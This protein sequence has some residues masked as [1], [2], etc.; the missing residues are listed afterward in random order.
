ML[1]DQMADL[2]MAA[3]EAPIERR[4]FAVVGGVNPRRCRIYESAVRAF[5][6]LM[7]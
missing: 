6:D 1:M 7:I 5:D 3:A 4:Y 2:M